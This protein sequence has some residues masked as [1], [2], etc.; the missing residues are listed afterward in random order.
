MDRDDVATLAEKA[1][2]PE[3]AAPSPRTRAELDAATE[4]LCR[5][6]ANIAD[7]V[8]PARRARPSHRR[9]GWTAAVQA[10]H[11]D[12][13]TALR[14]AKAAPDSEARQTQYEDRQKEFLET[15]RTEQRAEWREA[16]HKASERNTLWPLAKWARE[17]SGRPPQPKGTPP[18]QRAP[19]EQAESSAEGKAELFAERFFPNVT[20]GV[21]PPSDAELA[22]EP[23]PPLVH[24][25][26]DITEADVRDA[27]AQTA[28]WK[29]AGPDGLPAGFLK[30]CGSPLDK[31]LSKIYSTS[32]NLGYWPQ[33]FG[34]ANVA[35]IPKPGK[36]TE[37][38]SVPGGW[39]PISLLSCLAKPMEKILASRLL[40]KCEEE[41]MLPP[42][43]FGNRPKRSCEAAVRLVVQMVRAVWAQNS[44]ASLLQLDLKGAF[45]RVHH[46]W[47]LVTLHRTGLPA[48]LLKWIKGWLHGRQSSMR[49]DG[50][51]TRFRDI[52]AG[53]PQGSPLSPILFV[54][55]L[56][57]LYNRLRRDG[58]MLAGF[59]DDTNILAFGKTH[60]DNVS[61]LEATYRAAEKWAAEVGMQF[62]PAKSELI[63][64]RE[65]GNPITLPVRL[66][67]DTIQ[68]VPS[69]RF[70]G[71]WLD[72]RLRWKA[73]IKAIRGKLERQTLALTR[74]A[75][76]V[77]GCD[78][79]RARTLYTAVVRP[80]AVYGAAAV[81]EHQPAEPARTPTHGQPPPLKSR[82][83]I[84]KA[85]ALT[86]N[87]ALRRV[88]GAYKASPI[89][90]L[91][92]DMGVPPLDLYIEARQAVFERRLK[93][94]GVGQYIQDACASISTQLRNRR[95]LWRRPPALYHQDWPEDIHKAMH[96]KWMTRWSETRAG[97]RSE[98]PP[99][100]PL[101]PTKAGQT[102]LRPVYRGMRKAYTS[103]LFQARTGCI[104][105]RAFLHRV[106][107]PEF[108]GA[109]ECQCEH[110]GHQTVVH[111][112]TACMDP[113]SR[114]LR[115]LGLNTAES[116][117]EALGDPKRAPEMAR[118]LVG[119]GWLPEYRVAETLRHRADFEELE[120]EE[121]R[122]EEGE[123]MEES[124]DPG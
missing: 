26:L 116:V 39:R 45:D 76:S 13:R 21:F 23:H 68:P 81:V 10:K 12:A 117:G 16:L 71:V 38:L 74:L 14:R 79:P 67:A 120:K 123:A 69:A 113:R 42:E 115:E 56:A 94:S 3:L 124:E 51:E 22:A 118:R 96:E 84:G 83:V 119:S 25:N 50:E 106:G 70:L 75:A 48:Q 33:S 78:L 4:R 97:E 36:T 95:A 46:E 100:P 98:I 86:Q 66:G 63:H 77:W 35:V 20:P 58:I 121:R 80:L 5:I 7:L 88:A 103:V 1:L 72:Y 31:A 29:A 99:Q 34:R 43:Q 8:A 85:L 6:L 104:G 18:I 62:E 53:V 49:V 55:F 114:P 108:Q 60:R 73:H 47:L 110:G 107:V 24:M 15:L 111:L 87:K 109:P 40:T 59:A 41:G 91:E 105:L 64:F 90:V 122:G 54:L 52:P 57:P 37:Q 27:L 28:P 32:M 9:P 44:A 101:P 19:G 65:A 89:K 30:A 2:E 92:A 61:K 112:F 11:R 82:G 17:R 93:A 102:Q